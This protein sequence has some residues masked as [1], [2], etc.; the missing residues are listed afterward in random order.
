MTVDRQR[1]CTGRVCRREDRVSTLL[2]QIGVVVKPKFGQPCNG[3][4]A[5][6]ALELCAL[7]EQFF[8]GAAAPCPALEVDGDR[9]R[10]GLVLHPSRY[11]PGEQLTPDRARLLDDLVGPRIA[12]YLGV[13]KGCGMTDNHDAEIARLNG[14]STS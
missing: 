5:C 3:C 11:V 7:A 9:F 4:G 8:A 6:C 10:C 1:P 14:Q 2:V 12:Y 13:G